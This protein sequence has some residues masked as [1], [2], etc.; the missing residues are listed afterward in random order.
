MFKEFVNIEN[1]ECV[2]LYGEDY[3]LPPE[4]DVEFIFESEE[5]EDF[6]YE[7]GKAIT[8]RVANVFNIKS[9][10]RIGDN[11]SA[12]S[13]STIIPLYKSNYELF[14]RLSEIHLDKHINTLNLV[15][16]QK[17]D[18]ENYIDVLK[19]KLGKFYYHQ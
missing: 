11:I 4:E 3:N 9:I 5:V 13:S 10:F 17:I 14:C 7:N 16:Y 1:V 6:T 8:K 18:K 15:Y 2:I 12:F 19:E